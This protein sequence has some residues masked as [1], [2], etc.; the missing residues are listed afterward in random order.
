MYSLSNNYFV[1]SIICDKFYSFTL[2][3]NN[4]DNNNIYNIKEKE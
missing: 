2:C 1:F 3:S 4:N